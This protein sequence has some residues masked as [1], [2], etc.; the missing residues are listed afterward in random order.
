MSSNFNQWGESGPLVVCVHGSMAT[1]TTAF[2][3]QQPLGENFR[4]R[5]VTRPGYG[6]RELI[7]RVDVE[8]DAQ[9]LFSMLEPGSHL[10]GTSMG[11]IVSVI[12]AALRPDLVAS[13]TLIEPPAF[14]LA[15]DIP[16]VRDTAREL[17][18]TYETATEGTDREFTQRFIRALK[19]DLQLPDP[20]PAAFERAMRNVRT[21]RP[22]R[23]DVPIGALASHR[24]P[25]LV[26]GGGWSDAFTATARRVAGM[27]SAAFIELPGQLHGVQRVGEPF[28]RAVVDFWKSIRPKGHSLETPEGKTL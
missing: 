24:I 1:G 28:N 15:L 5:V 4:V 23:A 25:T 21:E 20:A 2:A 26:F 6:D 22:W 9:E 10:V 8:S 7:E 17:Q 13:L 27:L 19:L 12:A 18:R 14:P 3:A 11:G 16:A